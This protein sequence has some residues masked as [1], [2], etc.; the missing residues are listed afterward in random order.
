ML[1]GAEGWNE[2]MMDAAAKPLSLLDFARMKRQGE[3]I[4]CLT[5]YD[6]SFSAVLDRAGVD[7]ILVGDSLGMVIQ[8]H[9]TTL[10]VTVGDMVYH[11]R[12]VARGKERAFLVADL[13][14]M[15]YATLERAI[16][17]A[18][19]LLQEGAAQ[20]VKLEGGRQFGDTVR[21]LVE[22]GIPVCGHL[23]LLP[24]SVNQVGGYRV[25]GRSA[26]EAQR[27]LDD[28]V[29]LEQAGASLLV[30]ECVP[31]ALAKRITQ[32]LNI[33]T[34]GIGAG[35]HCDGQVLVLYDMLDIGVEH[36]PK[37]SRNFMRGADSIQGGI[38]AYVAAVRDGR[39]PREEHGF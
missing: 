17:S 4:V 15:S 1:A 20:M 7:V 3:K 25:Q 8:G 33:P 29:I 13:P 12:C 10:P 27:I 16:G 19:R 21:Y 38:G 11:S 35:M 28:S 31:S 37:F 18:T 36:R 26:E 34:I 6:A 2:S 39:F 9:R 24:Q 22:R 32:T 14:F 5:A 30:L 23:G